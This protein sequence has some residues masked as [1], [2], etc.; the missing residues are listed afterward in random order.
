MYTQCQSLIFVYLEIANIMLWGQSVCALS[1]KFDDR[2]VI[3]SFM[4]R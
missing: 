1:A 3:I 2:N 4:L